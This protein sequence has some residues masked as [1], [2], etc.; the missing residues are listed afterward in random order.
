MSNYAIVTTFNRDGYDLYGRKMLDAF[1]THW[2]KSQKIIVY[3]EG[4]KLDQNH[5][6]TRILI[7]DLTAVRDLMLFKKRHEN[8]PKAN[9][10]WP[11]DSTVKN[12]KFDAVRFS[13]KVFALYDCFMNRP[14]QFKSMVWLDA[15]TITFR[16]VPENFL[17]TIAPRSF[18]TRD[19]A[20]EQYG[21]SYLGRTLQHSECGFVS[22]NCLHPMM[23]AF[24]DSFIDLYKNDSCFD[25][26]EWHDSFLFDHVRV[27]FERSGMKN[28]NLSPGIA[29]GHPFINCRLG[30]YM[31]HM[32]GARKNLGRSRKAERTIKTDNEPDWWQ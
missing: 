10:Y 29:R 9:G 31:D 2:P 26:K 23:H 17:E 20:K 7:K 18:Y 24:W 19:G 32:K 6:D 21:I 3:A 27:K 8:N 12:F 30:E 22:Y 16:D 28:L 13:H 4:F 1:L 25:V 14:W 5:E 11:V 15:D